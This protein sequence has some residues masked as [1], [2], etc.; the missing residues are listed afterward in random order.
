M[1]KTTVKEMTKIGAVKITNHIGPKK[2]A[3]SRALSSA[4]ISVGERGIVAI[5]SVPH[6]QHRIRLSIWKLPLR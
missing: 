3:G 5:D 1:P 4:L 2:I 6:P